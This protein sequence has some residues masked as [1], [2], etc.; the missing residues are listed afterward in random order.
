MIFHEGGGVTP[1]FRQKMG[2]F[3]P[4]IYSP[5]LDHFK[6]KTYAKGGGDL[7][8]GRNKPY[9]KEVFDGFPYGL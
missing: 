2:I 7:A 4:K 6:A 9:S 5:F 1:Q 3:G 8:L